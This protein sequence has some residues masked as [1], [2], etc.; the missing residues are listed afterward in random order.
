MTIGGKYVPFDNAL[1]AWSRSEH[2]KV[3]E[4]VQ[5]P[6]TSTA[7]VDIKEL[8]STL[9]QTIQ[10]DIGKVVS[11]SIAEELGKMKE[12]LEKKMERMIEDGMKNALE[13]HLS[14]V[15]QPSM[16]FPF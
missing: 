4:P 5:S 7:Q 15:T 2:S 10:Q 11:G 14:R 8:I 3:P 13:K 12:R 6:P 9:S 16:S 1:Y